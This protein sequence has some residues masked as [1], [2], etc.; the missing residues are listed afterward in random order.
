MIV[1]ISITQ[2]RKNLFEMVNQAM[3]GK[4]VWVMYKG[5]RFRIAPEDPPPSRLDRIVPLNLLIDESVDDSKLLEEMTRAWER[6]W[7]EL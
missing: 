3:E 6:D 2:L 1:E 7:D 5:R 4:Q